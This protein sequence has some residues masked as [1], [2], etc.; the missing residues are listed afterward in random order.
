MDYDKNLDITSRSTVNILLLIADLVFTNRAAG[1][2][3]VMA[4]I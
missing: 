2:I 3:K 4:V 1:S